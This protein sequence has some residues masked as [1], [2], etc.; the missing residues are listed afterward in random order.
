[1]GGRF[2]QTMKNKDT[3]EE[4]L[5]ARFVVQG[6]KDSQ[7]FSLLHKAATLHIRSIRLLF[8]VASLFKF[9]VWT[10]DISQAYLQ[11]AEELLREVFMKTHTRI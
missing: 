1:M 10:Q 3:I 8:C 2:V 11:S 6:H 4:I 9:R 7:K 5:K